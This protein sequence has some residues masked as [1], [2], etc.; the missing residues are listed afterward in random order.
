MLDAS[1]SRL[2]LLFV[3]TFLVARVS[4]DG[5]LPVVINTW[6]FVDANKWGE[7][8]FFRAFRGGYFKSPPP[9][10]NNNKFKRPAGRFSHFLSPQKQFPPLNYISRKKTW[11]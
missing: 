10:K 8:V 6:P 2:F 3:G 9:K 7:S 1:G 11:T 4:C 5:Y